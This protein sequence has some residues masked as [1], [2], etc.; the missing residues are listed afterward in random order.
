MSDKILN[1][2]ENYLG[3]TNMSK[4]YVFHFDEAYGLSKNILGGKGAG[5]NAAHAALVAQ[6]TCQHSGINAPDAGNVMLA[7][8]L[9]Q[10]LGIAEV[11]GH[12]VVIAHNKAAD[13]GD[14]A[15]E[16][17]VGDA[18]VANQRISH[19]DKL[20]RVAG[21]ADQLLVAG[22]GCVEHDF[23]HP[24]SL[25]T[26]SIARIDAAVLKD[27]FSVEQLHCGSS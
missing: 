27:Q 9:F 10:R 4:Q 7:H 20:I 12:I 18:V 19:N 2:F 26:E 13:G 6:L 15:F 5:Q 21:I 23:A 24:L 14:A 3:G 11:G 25:C 16:I 1:M 22:H 8:H 17:I